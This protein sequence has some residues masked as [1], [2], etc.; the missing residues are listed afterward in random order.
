MNYGSLVGVVLNGPAGDGVGGLLSATSGVPGVLTALLPV[1]VLVAG[2]R[3][4]FR[5]KRKVGI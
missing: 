1:I 4:F 2:I 5:L 3:W